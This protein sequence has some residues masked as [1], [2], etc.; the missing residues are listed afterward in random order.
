MPLLFDYCWCHWCHYWYWLLIFSYYFADIG[1]YYWLAGAPFTLAITPWCHYRQRLALSA[2]SLKQRWRCCYCYVV[3]MLSCWYY[4]CHYA[5][6]MLSHA[7][8][9]IARYATMPFIEA[10]TISPL[11]IFTMP[12]CY[13]AEIRHYAISAIIA[14]LSYADYCHHII[15]AIDFHI[16]A[17]ELHYWHFCHY[18][19]FLW[20]YFR[21]WYWLM[22]Y[23]LL[24]Y[25]IDYA[26]FSDFAFRHF[27]PLMPPL[28]RFIISADYIS[29][30]C[31]A[32]YAIRY[33]C[34]FHYFRY[35]MPLMPLFSILHHADTLPHFIISLSA[36]ATFH[37]YAIDMIL[38]LLPLF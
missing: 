19:L 6:A 5:I 15:I 28:S 9:A 13:Y 30:P 11:A 25:F 12:A 22:L 8:S 17:I 1:Y 20:H 18:A 26:S 24:P 38:L 2:I 33:W 37:W 10:A 16:D 7:I 4:W 21:Y 36:F 35:A 31:H 27:T 14:E 3:A 32:T 23:W 29:M 34:H